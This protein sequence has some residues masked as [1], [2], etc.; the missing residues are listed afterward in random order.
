MLVLSIVRK[1]RKELEDMRTLYH[2]IKSDYFGEMAFEQRL[3]EKMK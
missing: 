1:L 3:K 2:E